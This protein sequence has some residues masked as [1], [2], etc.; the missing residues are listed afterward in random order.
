MTPLPPPSALSRIYARAVEKSI[1]LSVSFELTHRCNLRCRH[2]YLAPD[3]RR[4][5]KT[6]EI[7]GILDQLAEAKTLMLTLTGGEIFVREDVWMIAE[8]ARSRGFALRLFTNGTLLD[9]AAASRIANLGIVETAVSLYGAGA[10][11]HEFVTRV[12]GSF[13][14]SV[15][16]LEF[17]KN[18]GVR[19]TV[20]CVLMKSNVD[21]I[22]RIQA[23]AG[24]LGAVC[25]FDPVVSPKNDGDMGPVRLGLKKKDLIPVLAGEHRLQTGDGEAFESSPFSEDRAVCRAARDTASIGPS[26]DVFPCLQWPL[27]LGGLKTSSFSRIWGSP[28][29]EWVRGLRGLDFKKCLEC[30]I[31]TFCRLCPGLNF[32]DTGKVSEPSMLNCRIA[33]T[34][35]ALSDEKSGSRRKGGRRKR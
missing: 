8:A 14:R 10:A 3:H 16:A 4:E 34:R 13:R 1:P 18:A 12:P 31:S 11:M 23:L 6:A 21:A 35:W 30:N 25:Q 33:Q 24:R 26:G 7:V 32:L 29:A 28:R 9:E 17:L 15:R 27:R 22:D 19:T 5:L 2:C 20:K